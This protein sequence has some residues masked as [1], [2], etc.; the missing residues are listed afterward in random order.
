MQPRQPSPNH[1]HI[2]QESDISAHIERG[3]Q[4][5]RW[6]DWALDIAGYVRGSACQCAVLV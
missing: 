4:Q 3:H 1:P 2:E 5:T 6:T